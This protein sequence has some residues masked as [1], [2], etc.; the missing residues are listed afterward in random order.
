MR[1]R[2]HPAIRS[3]LN[4]PSVMATVEHSWPDEEAFIEALAF[5]RV[6]LTVA[7]LEQAIDFH[8]RLFG[9]HALMDATAGGTA[10]LGRG[11]R[12]RLFL[13]EESEET[14]VIPVV[15]QRLRVTV[16]ELDLARE[17]LWDK[18]V[19]V[20]RDVDERDGV[21]GGHGRSSFTIRDPD[22]CEIVFIEQTH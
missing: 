5:D 7:C 9:F 11:G 2:P 13:R 21:A 22:G 10:V 3:L 1:Y 18:G 16:A 12:A 14:A 19:P 6:W 20:T 17:L 4:M 15:G 8:E